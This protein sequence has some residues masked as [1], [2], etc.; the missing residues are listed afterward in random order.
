[1]PNTWKMP[2]PKEASQEHWTPFFALERNLE[3]GPKFTV[4]WR[5][6]ERTNESKVVSYI[7]RKHSPLLF[8]KIR[9]AYWRLAWKVVEMDTSYF[10]ACGFLKQ[11]SKRIITVWENCRLCQ[12][13]CKR[14]GIHF[15]GFPMSHVHSKGIRVSFGEGRSYL[16]PAKM[17]PELIER[18]KSQSI[19][20]RKPRCN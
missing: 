6:N 2:Q 4:N 17:F 10:A 7:E 20:S 8:G 13:Q 11:E 5:R 3:K 15:P 18:N 9:V 1:M 16:S 14:V 12:N 19:E